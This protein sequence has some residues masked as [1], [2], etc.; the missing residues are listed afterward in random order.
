MKLKVKSHVQQA[1]NMRGHKDKF[2]APPPDLNRRDGPYEPRVP[3]K[4][5]DGVNP[6]ARQLASGDKDVRDATFAALVKWLGS[7]TDVPLIDMKKICL[8]YTSPSPRD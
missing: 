8:L 1:R 6:F 5:N 7:R 2:P 3:T 4:E